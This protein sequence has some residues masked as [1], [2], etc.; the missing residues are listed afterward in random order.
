MLR[1]FSDFPHAGSR[2]FLAP[3]GDPVRIIRHNADG[4]TF[5]AMLPVAHDPRRHLDAAGNRTVA[6][7]DL[8]ETPDLAAPRLPK[9]R[10][11]KA[12]ASS[13]AAVGQTR[14]ASSS[15]AVGRKKSA[16]SSEAV[17]PT[18]KASSSAAVG[19]KKAA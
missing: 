2:A 5:V 17:G 10:K 19:R 11:R 16:S 4:T 14:T 1:N 15:K 6:F 13:S 9:R 7:A 8:F 12:K 18:K 3:H